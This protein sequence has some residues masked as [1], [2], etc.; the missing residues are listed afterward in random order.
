MRIMTVRARHESFVDAVFE[1][2][3]ELSANVGVAAVADLRL[4]L[5]EQILGG[6]GLVDRMAGGADDIGLRMGTAADVGAVEIFGVTAQTGI[7][8]LI[9]LHERESV[10]N[11]NAAAGRG[12]VLLPR[13]V[14]RFAANIF[15]GGVF[16]DGRLEMRIPIKL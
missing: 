5:C 16:G 8:D 12:D 3:R 14:T 1:R 13:S 4:F 7:Q 9:R 11:R 6:I 2:L 15:G 10:G